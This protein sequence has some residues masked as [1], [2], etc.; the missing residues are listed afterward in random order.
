MSEAIE[1]YKQDGTSAGIFYCSECRSVYRTKEEAD[2]CHGERTCECGGKIERYYSTCSACRNKA[3]K[4]EQEAK[5]RERFEKA[6]KVS[7]ADYKGGML[8]DG[9]KYHDDLESLED[10]LFDVSLPAY[11]WACKDIGVPKANSDSIIENLLENMW[12]DADH[13]DLNGLEELDAA[14]EKFNAANQ[15]ISVW[16]PDYSTAIILTRTDAAL[17][18]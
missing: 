16:E 2:G 4:A 6:E 14:I 8:F 17:T 18:N 11:V 3:W 15:S 1:L 5:E 7:Y 13:N 12:E 9:D 10:D